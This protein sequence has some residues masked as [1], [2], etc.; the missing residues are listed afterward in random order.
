[1]YYERV[2]SRYGNEYQPV[3]DVGAKLKRTRRRYEN[4]RRIH[5]TI[6]R[7]FASGCT[8]ILSQFPFSFLGS[9]ALHVST[10]ILGG[11]LVLIPGAMLAFHYGTGEGLPDLNEA[12]EEYEDASDLYTKQILAG[13]D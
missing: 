5:R 12:L 10:S 8:L 13:S 3:G 1:M 2:P 6:R 7:A 4:V 11:L 9:E